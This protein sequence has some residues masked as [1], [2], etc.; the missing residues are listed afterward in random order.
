MAA[1]ETNTKSSLHIRSNSLPSAPHPFTSQFEEHL[2][3]LKDSEA[4]LSSTSPSINY[5]LNALQDLHESMHELE[6]AIRRRRDDT[7][8]GL[9]I[10]SG[11]YL[12]SRKQLFIHRRGAETGFTIEGGKYLASRKNMKKEIRKALVILKG[13]KDEQIVTSLNKD[14]ETLIMLSILKESKVVIVSTLEFLLLFVTGSKGQPKQSK[15]SVISKLVQPNRVGCDSQESDTNE[16]VKVDAA[17]QPLSSIT[18]FV[19]EVNFL[20][21]V[22][23]LDMCIQNIEVGVERFLRQLIRIIVSLLNIF[24]H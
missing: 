11:K 1:I 8:A 6:S 21:H 10:A 23:N 7:E 9:T 17:L 24:N 13:I 22:K 16:F 14:N 4:A 12:A 20:N 19:T 2:H 3:R 15:W 5:K 18:S